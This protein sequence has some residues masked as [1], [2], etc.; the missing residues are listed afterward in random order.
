[1]EAIGQLT[2]GVAHDFN[3]L[4][5]VAQSGLDLM[6]RTSDPE[7]IE[8]LKAGIRHAIDRG[9]TLTQQLLPFARTS[10]LHPEVVDL[11]RRMPSM[12]TLLERTLREKSSA[13][14]RIAPQLRPAEGAPSD[15]KRGET[16]RRVTAQ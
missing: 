14:S 8:K 16:G 15:R 5:M 9:A 6:D 4:L 13:A 3:N 11:G 12:D 1:M 10:P 7:K 2:G